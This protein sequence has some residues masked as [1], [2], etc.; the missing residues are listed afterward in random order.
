[1]PTVRLLTHAT[2]KPKHFFSI[3]HSHNVHGVPLHYLYHYMTE[4]K[5][6]LFEELTAHIL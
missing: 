4:C 6:I 1:M 5:F 2:C 3:D